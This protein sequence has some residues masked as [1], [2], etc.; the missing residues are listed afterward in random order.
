[1]PHVIRLLASGQPVQIEQI[2]MAAGVPAEEVESLLRGQPGTDWDEQGRLVGFGLT[3]RP[4][5]HQ[6]LLSGRQLY[7]WCAMD[8]LL[9]PLILG[10]RA[11]AESRCPATGRAIRIDVAPEAVLSVDPNQ[12]VVSQIDA[13]EIN[14]L[15]GEVCDHGHF[16][17]SPE[18]ARGWATEHPRGCVLPV[19]DAFK[20]T[21][22]SWLTVE[23]SSR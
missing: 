3:Q 15:R 6:L 23:A 11:T 10:E 9:F 19:R 17:A 7:T 22:Q 4:T 16:F 18:A 20:Q 14:D 13:R 1:L 21:R 12:A 2:E 5:G 8:T